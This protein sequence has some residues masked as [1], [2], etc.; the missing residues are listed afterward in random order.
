M[1]KARGENGLLES[2]LGQWKSSH[3][4]HRWAAIVS[5]SPGTFWSPKYLPSFCTGHD[6]PLYASSWGLNSSCSIEIFARSGDV[7]KE[8]TPP[9]AIRKMKRSGHLANYCRRPHFQFRPPRFHIFSFSP[10]RNP[11]RRKVGS[12]E[13][14]KLDKWSISNLEATTQLCKC[15]TNE[16]RRH[17]LKNVQGMKSPL[18]NSPRKRSLS[19][20]SSI[21]ILNP[22]C[23]LTPKVK[24]SPEDDSRFLFF[25]FLESSKVLHVDS[26]WEVY[27]T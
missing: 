5:R 19:S 15:R 3:M 6:W 4:F 26:R 25:S 23:F 1:N 21:P 22:S 11:R 2:V 17:E 8:K 18:V 27:H 13:T 24:F 10:H 14:G 7:V 9:F 16:R 12:L 20:L